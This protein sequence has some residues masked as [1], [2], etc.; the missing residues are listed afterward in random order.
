[1]KRFFSILLSS[2]LLSSIAPISSDALKG[3]FDYAVN[4]KN[5]TQVTESTFEATDDFC[6]I[7]SVSP[8]VN[9][10]VDYSKGYSINYPNNLQADLS[11]SKLKTTLFDQNNILEIYYDNFNNT[12]DTFASYTN[13]SNKFLHDGQGNVIDWTAS[14]KVDGKNAK[15]LMWHREKLEKLPNDY[16]Y[17]ATA[18]I[19]RNNKEV[20]TIFL[21]SQSPITNFN[22]YLVGFNMIEKKA[23]SKINRSFENSNRILPKETKAFY[24]KYLSPSSSLKF[25]I[26]ENSAPYTFDYLKTLESRMDYNFPVVVKYHTFDEKMPIWELEN[27]SK[28][29]K[30]VELTLQTQESG[31]DNKRIT[32]DILN[33]YY[34]LYFKDYAKK[35]KEFGKPILFRLDNEMNGD[36]CT[37]SSYYTSKDTKLYIDKWKYIH[38]FFKEAGADN[39]LFVWNPHDKSFP[40]FAWNN[41]LNYYP[42]DDYV[43]VI[44]ITGYN[45]GT[46][47]PGEVWRTFSQIY[48]PVYNEY[49][50]IFKKPMMITE[51]ACAATGGDKALWIQDMFNN[52]SR[53]PNIKLAIWWNG[54]DWD[55]NGTPARIYKL[56]QDDNIIAVFKD[57]LKYYR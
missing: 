37:Y 26:F 14:T 3:N 15:V 31:K 42:G 36:W 29:K 27:A 40:N 28:E 9:K 41:Y 16:N 33:G 45:N 43:D 1:M 18:E 25:G 50:Q 55:S 11:V 48:D 6:Q 5:G 34:D 44:G 22:D 2:I 39:V 30:V 52:F 54:I 19:Q 21:K 53:Y 35:A 4:L 7:I 49:S 8:S 51:F 20:Y 57:N 32:Y 24:D 10:F 38:N 13:Y 12:L 56:D 46:Y 23:T 17:Y 47:Y